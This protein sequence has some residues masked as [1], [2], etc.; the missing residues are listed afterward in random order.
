MKKIKDY[1]IGEVEDMTGITQKQLRYWESQGYIPVPERIVCGDRAYRRYNE[2]HIKLLKKIR[3]NMRRGY[4]LEG[5]SRQA[6]KELEEGGGD[7]G[8]K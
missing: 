2:G 8:D 3:L 1:G 6:R 7:N 4:S 5:A